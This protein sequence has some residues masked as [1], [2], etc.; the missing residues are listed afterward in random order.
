[1]HAREAAVFKNLRAPLRLQEGE[2]RQ[3]DHPRRQIQRVRDKLVDDLE[4]RI[5]ENSLDAGRHL[6]RRQEVSNEMQWESIIDDVAG[7]ARVTAVAQDVDDG[8]A[9]GGAFPYPVR[10][11]LDPK[12]RLGRDGGRFIQIEFALNVAML[13]GLCGVADGH[14]VNLDRLVEFSD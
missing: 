2:P 6:G 11:S 12:Q 4:G 7:D 8:A 9:A 5:G 10:Q 3:H 14:D 13:S 1:V